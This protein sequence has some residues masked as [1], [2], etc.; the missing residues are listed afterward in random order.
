MVEKSGLRAN[1]VEDRSST[2]LCLRVDPSCKRSASGRFHRNNLMSNAMRF[3]ARP[4]FH[5]GH[6]FSWL[7]VHRRVGLPNSRSRSEMRLDEVA[8]R[9]RRLHLPISFGNLVYG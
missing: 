3:R 9:L 8:L 1:S 6:S 5:V 7:S 2:S 4:F